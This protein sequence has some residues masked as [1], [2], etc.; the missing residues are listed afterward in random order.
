MNADEGMRPLLVEARRTLEPL[1]ANARIDSDGVV[2]DLARADG[3]VL[4]PDYAHG[5]D[6]LL[7]VLVAEQRFLVEDRGG[8][9][10]SGRTY[11]DKAR[12]RL[13]RWSAAP[14]EEGAE[15]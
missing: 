10:V 5:P 14:A 15:P 11:L 1:L 2:I 6:E 8:G 3:T 12:E 9:A 7:A 4:W 13:R